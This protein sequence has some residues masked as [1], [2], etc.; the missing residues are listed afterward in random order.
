MIASNSITTGYDNKDE[1]IGIGEFLL[2]IE[3][4]DL[5]LRFSVRHGCSIDRMLECASIT[6]DALL[7]RPS[8]VGNDSYNAVLDEVIK[9][10]NDPLLPWKYGIA[11][12][13]QPLGLLGLLL[14]SSN[15]LRHAY[16]SLP[17]F[18]TVFSGYAQTLVTESDSKFFDVSIR[19]GKPTAPNHIVHFNTV[20]SIMNLAW[21]S[22]KL[23]ATEYQ[24]I[25]DE[26]HITWE[27]PNSGNINELLPSGLVVKFEEKENLL[28]HPS[29]QLNRPILSAGP[30]IRKAVL[31]KFES[32]LSIPP[33]GA[34]MRD[35]VRWLLRVAK[36]NI[37][38]IDIAAKKLNVSMATLKRQLKNEG[39]SYQEEKHIE[40][41][42]RVVELLLSTDLALEKIAHEVGFDNSSNLSKAFRTRFGL[43]P[44]QFRSEHTRE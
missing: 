28:R 8:H 38:T 44:G 41:Y 2:P 6:P 39:T 35:K 32:K 24:T 15:T 33:A 9:S 34:S 37:P 21:I 7:N 19:S 18:Y 10:A 36:P 27:A 17:A 11:L 25:N 23:T 20:A 5:M 26:V 13:E 30:D 14:R 31:E 16:E 1:I 42:N 12:S 29:N 4:F 43:T 22:R 3:A 40:R